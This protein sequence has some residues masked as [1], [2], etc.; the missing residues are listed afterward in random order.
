MKHKC[1]TLLFLVLP[2]L[3][4]T[5]TPDC[6]FT[7]TAT[8]SGA[9][10]PA[11]TN[12]FTNAS[13]PATRA[14]CTAW[15]FK[16]ATDNANAVSIQIE[17]AA[18]AV[19]LGHHAPTGSYTALTVSSASGSGSNPET[20]T[21]SGGAVLCCDY[22]PWIRLHV[23]TLTAASGTPSITVLV[24]GYK[25]N[26]ALQGGGGTGGITALTQDVTA[27]GSG[28]VPATVVGIDTVPLCTG[29]TPTEG[30]TLLYTTTLSPNPCYTA[31][32]PPTVSTL[33]YYMQNASVA[34][35]TYTSGGT[36]TGTATQTCTLA[37]FNGGGNSATATVALTG[38]N[39]IAGGTALVITDVGSQFTSAPTSA[40]L[41][42]GTAVC[43][44]TATI[45]TVLDG[46]PS[47]VSGDFPLSTQPYN[48]KTTMPLALTLNTAGTINMQSWVTPATE[49]GVSFIP[50][51][52]YECHLH[53]SRTNAFT[54]TVQLQCE[55]DEVSSTG[56]FIAKIGTTEPTANVSISET[57]YTLDYADGNVYTLASTASRVAVV[58]QSVQTSFNVAGNLDMYIGGE[59]DA[60]ILMPGLGASVPLLET[61]GTSNSVQTVLNLVNGT[62]CTVT[63]TSGGTV[64]FA[65]PGSGA[66]A[67]PYVKQS[68][69]VAQTSIVTHAAVAIG[70][71]VAVVVVG[72]SLP[73]SVS[74]GVNTYTQVVGNNNDGNSAGIFLTRAT[75]AVQL[76]ITANGAAPHPAIAYV[77]FVD[78]GLAGTADVTGS[79]VGSSQRAG[80]SLTTTG[81]N[82]VLLVACVLGHTATLGAMYPYWPGVLVAF[83]VGSGYGIYFGFG[84][85]P[86][87]NTY[88]V[89]WP[90]P[91]SNYGDTPTVA[92]AIK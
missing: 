14:G 72:D 4:Q 58:V 64:S 12:L 35:G 79:N 38:S 46:G 81:A 55:F 56:V 48:P 52:I 83:G 3:A 43:S 84:I 86:A 17:G 21:T 69:A 57:E 1:L 41:G 9:Q 66:A 88:I 44:G 61:N 87:A 24:Y 60:H 20:V 77:V 54:G 50:A 59:A 39:T 8:A 30:Q 47:D 65:C 6:Q 71:W 26:S 15:T 28:S 25:T 2:A 34:S 23:N 53:A 13:Q 27:S 31:V 40:T 29:F 89:G 73:S 76:T 51:G 91:N 49:P 78:P 62:G 74:D 5:S 85:L 80:V 19:T 16:Y 36:I 63:N 75:T 42:N 18:D 90:D 82:R 32:S 45:A 22:Y 11:V 68:D 92:A 33:L 37:T 7:F 10:S 67:P 70:D